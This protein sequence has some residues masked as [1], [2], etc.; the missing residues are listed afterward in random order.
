MLLGNHEKAIEDN[1][2]AIEL[3]PSIFLSLFNR[4]ISYATI[5]KFDEAIQDLHGVLQLYP[6][7]GES[8]KMLASCL[9]R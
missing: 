7:H 8:Y 1:T 3:D 9:I 6:T 2:N 5:N 4:A